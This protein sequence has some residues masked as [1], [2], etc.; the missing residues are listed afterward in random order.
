MILSLGHRSQSMLKIQGSRFV[1]FAIPVDSEEEAKREVAQIVREH[2]DATHCCFAYRIGHGDAAVARSDDAGEPAGSAGAP[3]LQV[4]RG[5][6]LENLIV[7]V[8][9]YFGGTKLGIGGLARAYRDAAKAAL[10]A[11]VVT[12]REA[13]RRLRVSVPLALVGEARSRLARLGGEV[14]GEAYDSR[15]ELSL[16]IGESRVDELRRSLDE[17][18]RGAARW[19]E[20]PRCPS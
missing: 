16:A 4:I 7:V 12:Q 13:L 11:G 14:L 6:G 17:L 20:N 15:A 9:R 5:R 19:E 1:G 8:I 18:T 2:P 10:D 3:I